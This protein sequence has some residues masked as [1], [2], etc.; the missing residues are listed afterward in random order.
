MRK[1]CSDNR[2]QF[3]ISKNPVNA[4]HV[5]ALAKATNTAIIEI[6]KG[7]GLET[8]SAMQRLRNKEK[9]PNTNT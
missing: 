3:S 2:D 6:W 1:N 4:V 9:R 5:A 8:M 7:L